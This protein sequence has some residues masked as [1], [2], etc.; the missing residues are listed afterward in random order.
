MLIT[1]T[2]VIEGKPVQDYLGV[3]TGEA[4]VGVNIFKDMF[5]GIRN[6]VGGRTASY[7]GELETARSAAFED[8][9]G[10][11]KQLRA[12]AIIG[13]DIDYEVIT[14]GSGSMLMV[15]VSGTAVRV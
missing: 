6:I 8:I 15:S 11:A 2:A 3:I 4:V 7:E 5:A 1:T 13:V 9:I 10:K 12:N 14:A